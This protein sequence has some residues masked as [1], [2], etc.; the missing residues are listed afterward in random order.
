MDGAQFVARTAFWTLVLME[1]KK[2][3]LSA[4]SDYF[5]Q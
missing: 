2:V 5:L 1:Y 4:L 3:L